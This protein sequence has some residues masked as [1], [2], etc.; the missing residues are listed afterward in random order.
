MSAG[1]SLDRTLSK[2]RRLAKTGD[3]LAAHA[4]Y[5]DVLARHSTNARAREG[6]RA[7]A[8]P[9]PLAAEGERKAVAAALSRIAGL[10]ASGHLAEALRLAEPLARRHPGEVRVQYALGAILSA[11]GRWEPAAAA[12][13]AAVG[14]QPTFIPALANLAAALTRLR[15]HEEAVICYRQVV[16]FDPQDADAQRNLGNALSAARRHEEALAAFDAVVALRPG[17]A[18]ALRQRGVARGQVGRYADAMADFDA[19]VAIAPGDTALQVERGNILRDVRR[20]DE[21]LDAYAAAVAHGS[22]AHLAY[23][24]MGVALGDLGR[25]DDAV[26]AFHSAI[27]LKPRYVQ[28]HA[29]LATWTRYDR[30]HPHIDELTALLAL[31]DDPV[32]RMYLDFALGKAFDDTGD[33]DRAFAHFTAGNRARRARAPYDR[34]SMAATFATI[35]AVFDRGSLPAWSGPTDD[36]PLPVFVVGMPRSGSSLTEQILCAH[37]GVDG[38]G[39]ADAFPRAVR[40]LLDAVKAGTVG[41]GVLGEV[42]AR[43]RRAIG[44]YRTGAPVIVD[45]YLANTRWLG[46][47]AAVFPE[48][49]VI[50]MSRDPVATCWS[51]YR[52]LFASS[53]NNYAYDLADLAHYHRLDT[54][55]LERWRALLPGRVLDVGY[56]RLTRE[57]EASTRELLGHC[58]LAYEPRCL[59]FH[60]LDRAVSTASA[61]QVRRRIYTGSS[62][63]W[64]RYEAH[65]GPLIDA[66][67]A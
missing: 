24:A 47:I 60:T 64:R 61:G 6:L 27:A 18:E 30:D 55:M 8:E 1:M 9:A 28:A 59:E 31:E 2:A 21:A 57:P 39:E 23:N 35:R 34:A 5:R 4:L 56:E 43:Y 32:G 49:P 13:A 33:T 63:A 53:G 29:N 12:F 7:L 52:K 10:T 66:L 25:T 20:H 58:G 22:R 45:K 67:R 36:G 54:A 19:A 17:D 40:P 46:F 65:L 38:V 37:S 3:Y 51:I 26:A 15:R 42:R 16:G 11:L 62:D 14:R 44:E 41:Q 50:A 48:A